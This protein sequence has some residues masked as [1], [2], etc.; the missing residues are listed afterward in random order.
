MWGLS[1]ESRIELTSENQYY[2]KYQETTKKKKTHNKMA[3]IT[4]YLSIKPLNISGLNSPM[5]RQACGLN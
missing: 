2:L 5:K 3:G 4:T 1:Q